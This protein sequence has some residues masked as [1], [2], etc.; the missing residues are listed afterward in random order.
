MDEVKIVAQER[1]DLLD[2][3]RLQSYVQAALGKVA[4]G[5]AGAANHY[6]QSAGDYGCKCPLVITP[7]GITVGMP[8]LVFNVYRSYLSA[9]RTIEALVFDKDGMRVGGPHSNKEKSI[10]VAALPGAVD[11]YVHIRRVPRDDTPEP[12]KFYDKTSGKTTVT[13]DTRTIDDYELQESTTSADSNAALRDAGW[14]DFLVF[15]TNGVDTVSSYT[16]RERHFLRDVLTWAIAPPAPDYVPGGLI[17]Y[18]SG[19]RQMIER[20]RYGAGVSSREWSDDPSCDACF[21]EGDPPNLIG[22]GIRFGDI[23]GTPGTYF[24]RQ[25][26]GVLIYGVS[27]MLALTDLRPLMAQEILARGCDPANNEGHTYATAIA[28]GAKAIIDKYWNIPTAMW[29]P[30]AD[31]SVD[32]WSAGPTTHNAWYISSTVFRWRIYWNPGAPA[33]SAQLLVPIHVP[34]GCRLVRAVLALDVLAA[35]PAGLDFVCGLKIINFPAGSIAYQST[36][37]YN[38]ASGGIWS[39]TGQDVELAFDSVGGP[40]APEV[41]DNNIEA[42]SPAGHSYCLYMYLD[43]STGVAPNN[44][45]SVLGATVKTE[46]REASHVY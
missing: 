29:T 44:Y 45:I 17:E 30:T 22:G 23:A 42:P 41:I 27:A 20:M 4:S 38:V 3:T 28:G 43:D 18:V 5:I 39:A 11:R 24:L 16:R 10:T 34:H 15:Q 25:V 32:P 21:E 35:F 1:F 8:S 26:N 40:E 7:F 9:G 12:R 2:I 46:I 19:L 36:H 14:M 13:V 31:A 6:N 37:I 33:T